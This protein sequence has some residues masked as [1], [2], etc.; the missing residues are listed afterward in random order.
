MSCVVCGGCI[1][2]DRLDVLPNTTVCVKCAGEGFGE[3]RVVSIDDVVA[4]PGEPH[5]PGSRCH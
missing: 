1:S 3:R 4:H 2:V 5:C